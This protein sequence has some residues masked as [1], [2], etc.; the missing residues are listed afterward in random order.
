M[1]ILF[2]T[3]LWL[4]FTLNLFFSLSSAGLID[5]RRDGGMESHTDR[6]MWRRTDRY[7]DGQM[8]WWTDVYG[9]GE[10]D[11]S[12]SKAKLVYFEQQSTWL[13][14]KRVYCLVPHHSSYNILINRN[15]KIIWAK[16]LFTRTFVHSNFCC[17]PIFNLVILV[18]LYKWYMLP[19]KLS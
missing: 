10:Q 17:R 14:C 7:M 5:R 3:Y 6:W 11:K 1:N 19:N 13:N 4:V 9:M 2:L 12:S 16:Y 18:K 8:D 15:K